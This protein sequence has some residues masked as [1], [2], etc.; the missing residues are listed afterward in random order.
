VLHKQSNRA[1]A[2]QFGIDRNAIQRHRE[3]IPELL[4]QAANHEEVYRVEELLSRVEELQRRTLDILECAEDEDHDRALRAI[5][6]A[7]SNLEL[8]AKIRQLIDQ[9]PQVNI[10]LFEHPD[11]Q[12][13]EDAIVRAL[14]PYAAARWAVADA[15]K[16]IE[17]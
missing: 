4:I 7:R 5:R 10:A 17:G 2:S 11:Y 15:L 14:E 12:R 9:A 16:E 8:V 6:E 1:I 13:L 3:H